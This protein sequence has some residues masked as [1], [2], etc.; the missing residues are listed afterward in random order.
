MTVVISYRQR[1]YTC[2]RCRG[3][4]GGGVKDLGVMEVAVVVV[5]EFGGELGG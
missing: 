2:L 3:S 1:W 5:A 4:G